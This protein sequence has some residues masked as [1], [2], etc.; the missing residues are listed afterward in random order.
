LYFGKRQSPFAQ[1]QNIQATQTC[2]KMYSP[3]RAKKKQ[4]KKKGTNIKNK[5]SANNQTKKKKKIENPTNI[6]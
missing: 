1:K 4:K 5:T 2:A 3:L 6:K